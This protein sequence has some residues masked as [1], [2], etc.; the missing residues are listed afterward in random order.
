MTSDPVK[1]TQLKDKA[2][3][4]SKS[5]KPHQRMPYSSPRVSLIEPKSFHVET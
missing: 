1:T 2:E 3:I 4:A 5:P